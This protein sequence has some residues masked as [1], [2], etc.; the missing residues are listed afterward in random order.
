MSER[1]AKSE[2]EEEL[3][4]EEKWEEKGEEKMAG[5]KERARESFRTG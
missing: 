3:W 1:W 5:W 4:E 2:E